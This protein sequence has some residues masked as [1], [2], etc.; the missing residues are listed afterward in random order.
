MAGHGP[1]Q[2]EPLGLG[3]KSN[4]FLLQSNKSRESRALAQYGE[5]K[6][7]ELV[8]LNVIKGSSYSGTVKKML[9][10]PTMTI[11]SLKEVPIL[12]REVRAVLKE[13]IENW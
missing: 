10:V 7:H 11:M 1:S 4:G 6:L 3:S 13:M 2:I 5:I 12:S 9:H 8:T